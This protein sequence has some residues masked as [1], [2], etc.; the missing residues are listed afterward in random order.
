MKPT[1]KDTKILKDYSQ[2][3]KYPC[4][5]FS[6]QP[7]QNATWTPT[8]KTVNKSV[9]K[10]SPDQHP[11]ACKIPRQGGGFCQSLSQKFHV[12]FTWVGR[13]TMRV[14]CLAQEHNTM[15][16]ARAQTLTAQSGD[17]RTSHE[18]SAPVENFN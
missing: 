12:R 2:K 4:Q 15:S 10:E 3:S 14:K 16:P 6:V 7:T 8:V 1:P 9:S 5:G 13:G 17:K 11:L 18:T